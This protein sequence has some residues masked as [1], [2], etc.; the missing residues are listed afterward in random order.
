MVLN[1]YGIKVKKRLLE[2]GMTQRELAKIVGI[3]DKNMS[4]IL[5]GDRKGWKHRDRINEVL[6]STKSRRISW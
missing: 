4:K 6:E 1:T 2:I 3:S 5:C